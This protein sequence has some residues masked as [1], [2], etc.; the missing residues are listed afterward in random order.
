L[1]FVEKRADEQNFFFAVGRREAWVV[2][3]KARGQSRAR[4]IRAKIGDIGQSSRVAPKLKGKN[5]DARAESGKE[6]NDGSFEVKKQ[7]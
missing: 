3:W 4:R 2:G 6:E 5:D 1:A 7:T